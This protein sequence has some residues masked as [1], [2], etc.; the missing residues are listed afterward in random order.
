MSK[1][2]RREMELRK[3]A[4]Q[5]EAREIIARQ[6]AAGRFWKRSRELWTKAPTET[7]Q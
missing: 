3:L 4:L 6:V 5:K 7:R 2:K 1:K